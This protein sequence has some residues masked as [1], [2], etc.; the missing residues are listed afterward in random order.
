MRYL[1]IL[2]ILLVLSILLGLEMTRDTGYLLIVY[3]HW[4]IETTLWAAILSL[5]I[6]FILFYIIFRLLGRA[7]RLSKNIHR[8]RKMKQYRRARQLTTAGL[9]ELAEGRWPSAEQ[10][11]VKGAKITKNPLVNYLAAAQAANAQQSYER[12]DNYL[13]LAHTKAKGSDI[14]VD[15]T[16]ARLQISKNQWEQALAT[17]ERVNRANPNHA[18]TLQ[19]LKQVYV[20][21]QDWEK[22]RHLLP[23]L[24]KQKVESAE[25]LDAFEKIIYVNLLS[26]A[27]RKGKQALIAIWNSFPRR[28]TQE[29]ELI[30]V[31]THSL[32]KYD[33]GDKAIPLIESALKKEWNSNLVSTYGLARGEKKTDQLTTAETWL[34]KYPK[35]PELFLCLGRLSRREKF[36]GKARD[37]LQTSIKLMPSSAAY[38]ELGQVYEE[39]NQKDSAL[40]CYRKALN[41]ETI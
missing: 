37:Y 29:I 32:I 25:A 22:L 3:R 20:H 13:R 10:K 30:D 39:Q 14:A 2:F 31:Y 8:W 9:C 41:L 4:S 34:K 1:I 6:L 27:D 28:S 16:Q 38:R 35:E 11:L 19:L 12:R 26:A 5:L 17:L 21:L 18:C 24:R 40:D 36:L 33:E 15:L 7:A 23:R